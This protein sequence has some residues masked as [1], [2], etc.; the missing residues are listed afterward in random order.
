MSVRVTVEK[1]RE[2]VGDRPLVRA[3]RDDGTEIPNVIE[4]VCD[5]TGAYVS[6]HRSDAEGRP[7][8]CEHTSSVDGCS[9]LPR[10]RYH[11][12]I[13]KLAVTKIEGGWVL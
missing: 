11:E 7:V 5:P 10:S 12:V 13:D 6:V 4:L 1:S 9:G 2:L 3:F 8:L